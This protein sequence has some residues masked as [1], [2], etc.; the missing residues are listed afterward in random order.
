MAS[1]EGT[2]SALMAGLRASASSTSEGAGNLPLGAGARAPR[3]ERCAYLR[4][5][6]SAHSRARAL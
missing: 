4:M 6:M 1:L 5:D 3:V 2:F